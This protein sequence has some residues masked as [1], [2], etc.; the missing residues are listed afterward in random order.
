[1]LYVPLNGVN[2]VT[3]ANRKLPSVFRSFARRGL[4]RTSPQLC[5]RF[6]VHEMAASH[7]QH[8]DVIAEY[9]QT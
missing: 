3:R 6:R 5:R 2:G 7:S 9:F 4:S 1:L 8:L